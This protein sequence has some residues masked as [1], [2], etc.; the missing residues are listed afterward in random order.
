MGFRMSWFAF[1]G[2]G[3][4][5]VLALAGLTD[6][7]EPED[8]GVRGKTCAELPNGWTV[9]ADGDEGPFKPK[10]MAQL[11]AGGRVLAVWMSETVMS[12]SA[13]AWLEGK[14]LWSVSHDPEQSLDDLLVEGD[15][16][17]ALA[18]IGARLQARQAAEGGEEAETDY[19]FDIA[20]EISGA[21]CGWRPDQDN[22]AWGEIE[23]TRVE[24]AG[25]SDGSPKRSWLARLLGR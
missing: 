22:Q 9:L 6:T 16:P 12:S 8:V 21:L 5:D 4:D 20:C 2:R 24:R 23:F 13:E 17:P 3:K 10:T 14:R 19:V 7:G 11:S 18:A 15:F 1:E 25:A